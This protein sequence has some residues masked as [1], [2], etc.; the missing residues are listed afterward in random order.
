MNS[1]ITHLIWI[2][3]N[4][5]HLNICNLYEYSLFGSDIGWMENF[6]E[7]IGRETFLDY[8]W[9]SEEEEK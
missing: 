4:P 7:K 8:V 5:T 6:R 9:L 3:L 1:L 2:S